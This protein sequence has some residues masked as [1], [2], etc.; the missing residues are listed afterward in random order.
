MSD[1]SEPCLE[2]I[3]VSVAESVSTSRP[4]I[5]KIVSDRYR[6]HDVGFRTQVFRASYDRDVTFAECARRF[7]IHVSL[8]YRWRREIETRKLASGVS[9]LIPVSLTQEWAA[10]KP[11]VAAEFVEITFAS[12]H[13]LRVSRDIPAPNLDTL[14]KLLRR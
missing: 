13:T 10:A 2:T 14:V 11:P 6:A 12:G 8:L 5:E 3:A 4:A 7:G 1:I 9:R